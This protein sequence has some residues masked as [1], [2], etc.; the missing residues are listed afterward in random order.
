MLEQVHLSMPLRSLDQIAGLFVHLLQQLQV[1][2]LS[3]I[4]L[5]RL[6]LHDLLLDLTLH[7]F[8]LPPIFEVLRDQEVDAG[9]ELE[10]RLLLDLQELHFLLVRLSVAPYVVF[11]GMDQRLIVA[12]DHFSVGAIYGISLPLQ[13]LQMSVR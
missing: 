6:H 4:G 12:A 2:L 5:L 13:Y 1:L 11:H 10:W 8:S 3:L 9:I 7:L